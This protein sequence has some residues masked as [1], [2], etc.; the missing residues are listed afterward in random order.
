MNGRD[1][2]IPSHAMESRRRDGNKGARRTPVVSAFHNP[3]PA[4]DASKLKLA[5][6]WN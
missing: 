6:L 2:P 3:Q 4:V 1:Y 5:I